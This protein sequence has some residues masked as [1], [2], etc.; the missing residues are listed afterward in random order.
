MLRKEIYIELIVHV[1][2]MVLGVF[3]VIAVE[4]RKHT[5]DSAETK[6]QGR[7]TNKFSLKLSSKFS[8]VVQTEEKY[9]FLYATIAT[10]GFAGVLTYATMFGCA[11]QKLKSVRWCIIPCIAL[12]TAQTFTSVLIYKTLK[13]SAEFKFFGTFVMTLW[14]LDVALEVYLLILFALTM[15]SGQYNQIIRGPVR[16]AESAPPALDNPPCYQLATKK[17]SVRL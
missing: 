13:K 5:Y 11:K 3:G 4:E 12:T 15:A 17:N 6:K 1:I 16:D 10:I 2:K 9:I 14:L 7:N 8:F